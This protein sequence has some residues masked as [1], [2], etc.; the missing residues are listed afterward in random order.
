MTGMVKREVAV[1]VSAEIDRAVRLSER[2]LHDAAWQILKAAERLAQNANLRSAYLHWLLAGTASQRD[3]AEGAAENILRALELDAIA[4]PFRDAHRVISER[5]RVTFDEL[6]IHDVAVENVFR[7]LAR[8]G[9]VDGAALVKRSRHVASAG[10][11][12]A[13]LGL[14]QEAVQ[15]EPHNAAA[16]RHLASLLAKVGRHEEARVHRREAEALLLAFPC[17]AATA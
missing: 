9:A 1:R 15:R 14:A 8:L 12:E 2:G 3:D 11:D 10:N 5:V 16:L 6:D 13:A 17:R 7:L 4:P